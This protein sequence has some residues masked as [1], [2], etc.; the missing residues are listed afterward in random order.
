MDV[1]LGIAR[2]RAELVM[3]KRDAP[4]IVHLSGRKAKALRRELD[5]LG[6]GFG[7]PLGC[8]VPDPRDDE[9]WT[10]LGIILDDVHVYE[11]CRDAG[12]TAPR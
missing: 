7:I 2:G 4:Y 9:G 8:F 6:V 3:N 11:K 1:L 5:D 12:V 10:Y